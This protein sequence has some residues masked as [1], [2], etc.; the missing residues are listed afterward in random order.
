MLVTLALG[1]DTWET[2]LGKGKDDVN[3]RIALTLQILWKSGFPDHTLRTTI[4]AIRVG[5]KGAHRSPSP[6]QLVLLPH[7]YWRVVER[8]G[9]RA[10]WIQVIPKSKTG[11]VCFS[12]QRVAVYLVLCVNGTVMKEWR[13][14]TF[15]SHK[16]GRRKGCQ[17][18]KSPSSNGRATCWRIQTWMKASAFQ[19]CRNEWWVSTSQYL[20]YITNLNA[21]TYSLQTQLG[22]LYY[23]S[24]I[25]T[26]DQI[27][28]VQ[29]TELTFLRS[30]LKTIQIM[31]WGIFTLMFGRVA[32][33]HIPLFNIYS[34]NIHLFSIFIECLLYTRNTIRSARNRTVSGTA[35]LSSE[36]VPQGE[37]DWETVRAGQRE[38]LLFYLGWSAKVTFEL[39][40]EQSEEVS[41]V[42]V[43]GRACSCR[44]NSKCGL[45]QARSQA[46]GSDRSL[47]TL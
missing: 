29:L 42:G 11:L 38:G 26:F 45:K 37:E 22:Q 47:R 6:P 40:L 7:F 23:V 18:W 31:D 41:H 8:L 21:K 39:R 46:Q 17:D 34:L 35:S 3:M 20:P 25:G 28:W 14:C 12:Y 15:L 27:L 4:Q 9:K 36:E 30:I 1:N 5:C 33:W 16:V 43:W 24:L 10:T 44:S 32:S 13:W 2:R 19:I